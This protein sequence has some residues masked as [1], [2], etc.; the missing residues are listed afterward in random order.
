MASFSVGVVVLCISPDDPK[1][2]ILNDTTTHNPT[3]VTEIIAFADIVDGLL[4]VAN[5]A[6]VI[7]I[8]WGF[9]TLLSFQSNYRKFKFTDVFYCLC[10]LGAVVLLSFST[11]AVLAVNSKS[12]ISQWT[13][14]HDNNTL[15]DNNSTMH[16]TEHKYVAGSTLSS[17]SEYSIAFILSQ[18]LQVFFSSSFVIHASQM[19]SHGEIRENKPVRE[20]VQFVGMI[21]FFLWVTDSFIYSPALQ[22]FYP[23]ELFYFSS[24]FEVV[25]KLTYPLVIFYHFSTALRCFDLAIKY[26]SMP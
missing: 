6:T 4:F 25:A 22:D 26:N 10:C 1:K 21:H 20:A 13:H 5:I 24:S 12:E 2:L 14:S 9:I 19:L 7:V 23:V 17:M 8:F 15:T 3:L 18:L 16:L 11:I